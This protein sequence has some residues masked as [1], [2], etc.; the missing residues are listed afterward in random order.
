MAGS[1]CSGTGN[2]SRCPHLGEQRAEGLAEAAG[3]EA[4]GA[5]VV[6]VDARDRAAEQQGELGRVVHRPVPE[7]A[8]RPQQ[9][10]RAG[11]PGPVR[12]RPR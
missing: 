6:D 10:R 8:R 9:P 1:M 5:V 3:L 11:R 2:G 4:L 7:R 12:P